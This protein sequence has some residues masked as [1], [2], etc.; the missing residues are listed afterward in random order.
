MSMF[1]R[2]YESVFGSG[3]AIP[4]NRKVEAT[5]PERQAIEK[6][7]LDER[8]MLL[9]HY[10]TFQS[11]YNLF[12]H[13][14]ATRWDEAVRH[15]L[16]NAAAMKND[17]Y[18]RALMAER[19]DPLGLW[20]WTIKADAD[21]LNPKDP[22]S[23]EKAK[24][25]AML[26]AECRAT[27][28]L[29]K[30]RRHLGWAAW[31]GR[32]GNQVAY[33]VDPENGLDWSPRVCKLWSPVDGDKLHWAW[34][35]ETSDQNGHWT[36][37]INNTF[38]A[39]Y[40]PGEVLI[41]DRTTALRLRRLDYR[42]RF[43]IATGEIEDAPFE[44]VA[45]AGRAKGV[46]L[47]DFLY[48][49]WW[50]R[51]EMLSWMVSLAEKAGTLGLLMFKYPAGN[52]A[53]KAKAEENAKNVNN[54]NALTVPVQPGTK[55][56]DYGVEVVALPTEGLR[57]LKEVTFDY[58]DKHF[59]RLVIG[60]TLSS[61]TEGSGLG[62]A[63]VADMHEDTKFARLK[64]D[65]RNQE[66]CLTRDF[67]KVLKRLNHHEAPGVYRWAY[68][69]P[70]PKAKDKLE[71]ITKAASL[72]GKK[73][74]YKADEV[75]ALV[76]MSKPEEG[77]EVIG[78]ED[79]AAAGIDPKTGLPMP[80]GPKPPG[81]PGQPNRDG[82]PPKESPRAP[83]GR[84]EPPDDPAEPKEPKQ[85][86]EY[87]FDPNQSRGQPG[88]AGQFGPGGSGGSQSDSKS[89][90]EDHEGAD[91]VEHWVDFN[92][93]RSDL[94]DAHD[95]PE[96]FRSVLKAL[97]DSFAQQLAHKDDLA[98]KLGAVDS[99]DYVAGRKRLVSAGEKYLE[100]ME[101][102]RTAYAPIGAA[103]AEID[104]LR[105]ADLDVK[106]VPPAENQ[107]DI[108]AHREARRKAVAD[109][110]QKR[111]AQIQA[112]IAKRNA[113]VPAYRDALRR[114]AKSRQAYIQAA[115]GLADEL[116]KRTA[117]RPAGGAAAPDHFPG[118]VQS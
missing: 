57:F 1:T 72:P 113:A 80:D 59:E 7:A 27:P 118:R 63:G 2:V 5:T 26:E 109:A 58:F 31:Y 50:L 24:V 35:D 91:A 100:S 53:A 3:S 9:P 49:G 73:L 103:K 99:S 37:F 116:A 39:S 90:A 10:R 102:S 110:K 6:E 43:V 96:Q 18:F 38:R 25:A 56:D 95:D 108:E 84:R 51:D 107:A 40:P 77:D 87:G 21:P 65:A 112:V 62:G 47:R 33:E 4:E 79:P 52:D 67:V 29:M 48:W 78:G 81:E 114:M 117:D 36:V 86:R 14:Y 54:R 76:G 28:D 83:S 8:G 16:E 68:L 70:D 69:L 106:D 101:N 34:G 92:D 60:Q 88:N 89:A 41:N 93:N 55:A 46:G 105:D 64:V 82:T 94:E 30:F 20:D 45:G 111:S 104:A 42:Q 74:E 61:S 85:P 115:D 32:I 23:E 71:A 98:A 15:G 75:R 11:L 66:E 17:T 12:S 97:A 44:D 19:L 22:R 13:T